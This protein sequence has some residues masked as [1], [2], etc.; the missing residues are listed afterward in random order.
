[1]E[2]STIGT[3]YAGTGGLAVPA[4]AALGAPEEGRLLRTH[5][6][7]AGALKNHIGALSSAEILRSMLRVTPI[8][9]QAL[10]LVRNCLA[11]LRDDEIT[12]FEVPLEFAINSNS[13]CPRLEFVHRVR[14][15]LSEQL[16][17][18]KFLCLRRVE[19]TYFVVEES[20][21][22]ALPPSPTPSLKCTDDSGGWDAGKS[23]LLSYLR[24]DDSFDST[25]PQSPE[26]DSSEGGDDDVF[27][28]KHY[29]VPYWAILGIE[30]GDTLLPESDNNDTVE[31]KVADP[32]V[33][34]DLVCGGL[35][36]NEGGDF[37]GKLAVG[38]V[39]HVH[40]SGELS[41]N[42]KN[43]TSTKGGVDGKGESQIE[44]EDKEHVTDSAG[45]LTTI[46]RPSRASLG[47]ETFKVKIRVSLHHPKGTP[48][49]EGK[50]KVV[51][52]LH[53][54]LLA[55]ERR[56]NQLLLLK[57]MADT[58]AASEV[59]IAP[60]PPD[61]LATLPTLTQ[62]GQSSSS[63][64]SA[65][66][67][68]DESTNKIGIGGQGGGA[69]RRSAAHGHH[70]RKPSG[71]AVD[72]AMEEKHITACRAGVKLGEAAAAAGEAVGE[73]V[74]KVVTTIASGKEE[75]GLTLLSRRCPATAGLIG[76]TGDE[77]RERVGSVHMS[78]GAGR[79]EG[80]SGP[81]AHS[82]RTCVGDGQRE[83]GRQKGRDEE[84]SEWVMG[85]E[86][87]KLER[88]VLTELLKYRQLGIGGF[89]I[90]EMAC[91]CVYTRRFPLYYRLH[92]SNSLIKLRDKF[93]NLGVS[94]QGRPGVLAY[95]T[96]HGHIFYILLTEGTESGTD[97]VSSAADEKKSFIDLSVHGVEEVGSDITKDLCNV[98]E[99]NIFELGCDQL[100]SLLRKNKCFPIT[101]ADREFIENCGNAGMDLAAVQSQTKDIAGSVSTESTA[102]ALGGVGG[103]SGN[104]GAGEAGNNAKGS[105]D[106]EGSGTETGTGSGSA[107]VGVGADGDGDGPT[108]TMAPA[109]A[110]LP[111]YE[112][113][114]FF[115]PV[116]VKDLYL[117]LMYLRQAL[118]SDEYIHPLVTAPHVASPSPP[119]HP[120]ANTS[121]KLTSTADPLV[122]VSASGKN[123]AEADG[124]GC[125][126]TGTEDLKGVL[127]VELAE[128]ETKKDSGDEVT[129]AT[130]TWALPSH[131]QKTESAKHKGR[132]G[133]PET[134]NGLTDAGTTLSWIQ[135]T[136]VRGQESSGGT[137]VLDSDQVSV[138][139]DSTEEDLH[140][141]YVVDTKAELDGESQ[142][143]GGG[144]GGSFIE[145]VVLD[146]G[147]LTF[148]YLSQQP[149]K[150]MDKPAARQTP[151][152]RKVGEGVAII[153]LMPVGLG[154]GNG[155]EVRMTTL[156][157]GHHPE[158]SIE[159][160]E[161][162]AE[163]AGM[164]VDVTARSMR[165][166][167]SSLTDRRQSR[168]GSGSALTYLIDEDNMEGEGK[169][170][171]NVAEDEEENQHVEE[172]GMGSR[173]EVGRGCPCIKLEVYACGKINMPYL[174]DLLQ[175]CF[176][177]ALVEYAIERVLLRDRAGSGMER[178]MAEGSASFNGDTTPA[179][180]ATA[181]AGGGDANSVEINVASTGAEEAGMV[182]KGSGL[183]RS[184]VPFGISPPLSQ[185]HQD[186]SGHDKGASLGD[187]KKVCH[188]MSGL[189]DEAVKCNSHATVRV[190]AR[191]SIPWYALLPIVR[192]LVQD[193]GK[194]HVPFTDCTVTVHLPGDRGGSRGMGGR[195][196]GLVQQLQWDQTSCSWW[197]KGAP[198]NP[199]TYLMVFG[200]Y[201][202]G[203]PKTNL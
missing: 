114:V 158:A 55:I 120:V 40:G 107:Q 202:E 163:E 195:S 64:G 67:I 98:I 47:R 196:V 183:V 80:D 137:V 69:F 26:E 189:M 35:R 101:F 74:T 14:P 180:A 199:G 111:G 125:M 53:L 162:L 178:G 173:L 182:R 2:Q 22:D 155:Q 28:A 132:E 45:K 116:G 171:D 12:K 75:G 100:W 44:A 4:T 29:V 168:S 87:S 90:G 7:L 174:M 31:V 197:K 57:D 9:S 20:N 151:S 124:V 185:M 52:D 37:I 99:T 39:A 143:A 60:P 94:A 89:F 175:G 71:G 33:D 130:G 146:P 73:V 118:C 97:G 176:K 179:V 16:L 10:R 70:R 51:I 41:V 149:P 170:V 169:V 88:R 24:R 190:E 121:P 166:S 192:D 122:L 6:Q 34:V 131:G 191:E 102:G 138:L 83:D 160:L 13:S 198:N 113:V 186:Q 91:P 96:H 141:E 49:Y 184:M 106:T 54:R 152:A 133:V 144:S 43:G 147:E 172:W 159:E 108:G 127:G 142:G 126:R 157:T 153:D 136:A 167:S 62:L 84:D 27:H 140:N 11:P 105:A 181:A 194:R 134:G 18:G 148:F 58:Q 203:V 63:T 76:G 5:E 112:S 42:F 165:F 150:N 115:L 30:E 95:R 187:V 78:E 61:E 81:L 72:R 82:T 135:T 32:G 123:A 161:S 200:M 48:L 109:P 38:S 93:Q 164:G 103:T 86:E 188:L 1:E 117:F 129:T 79:C 201:M 193:V 85:R 17:A 154:K 15:L 110:V 46:L 139:G 66:C 8:T 19:D 104:G 156:G 65:R 50:A 68:L 128:A 23:P 92:S 21:S 36:I 25:H 3:R 56:V 145:E 177:Q 77:S 119:P 59:L